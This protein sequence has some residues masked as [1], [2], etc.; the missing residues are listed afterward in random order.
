MYYVHSALIVRNLIGLIE[1]KLNKQGSNISH[2]HS[3]LLKIL[4]LGTVYKNKTFYHCYNKIE[5]QIS[6]ES[7]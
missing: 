5:R 4:Y 3:I 6:D 2:R 1:E 7:L